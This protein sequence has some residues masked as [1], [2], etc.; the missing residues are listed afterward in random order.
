[1]PHAAPAVGAAKTKS[2]RQIVYESAV[3]E[4]KKNP[5]RTGFSAVATA[6]GAASL[7]HTF[8][9]RDVDEREDVQPDIDLAC[10]LLY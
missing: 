3:E 2:L 7:Y 4:V 9:Q 6:M 10:C 8:R 5:V 1:M